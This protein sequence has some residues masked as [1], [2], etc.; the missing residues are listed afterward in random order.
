MTPKQH[1]FAQGLLSGKNGSDAYRA[2]YPDC[3]SST[4]VIAGKACLLGK[5]PEIVS[6]IA[7][8]RAR[9][10]D[11]ALLSRIEKRRILAKIARKGSTKAGSVEA[12]K[13]DNSMSGD[14]A[15]QKIEVFGLHELLILVRGDAR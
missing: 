15:P 1:A 13:V 10:D 11:K 12:I 2:A 7:Q 4:R 5:T 6:Y 8:E 9:M 3:K 14:N